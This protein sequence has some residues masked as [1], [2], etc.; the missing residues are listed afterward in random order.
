MNTALRHLQNTVDLISTGCPERHTMRLFQ[1][2]LYSWLL[3]KTVLLLPAATSLWGPHSYIQL[4]DPNSSPLAVPFTLLHRPEVANYFWLFIACQIGCLAAG[5]GGI[6][7]RL[8]ALGIF[9][10]TK[11]LNSR[12]WAT[13]NGGDNLIEILLLFSLFMHPSRHQNSLRGIVANVSSNV[14]FWAA[15]CQLAIVYAVSGLSK[16]QGTL[17]QHGTALYYVL[18]VDEYTHPLGR[19]IA[20]HDWLVTLGSFGTM[21]FMLSFPCLIWFRN[22]RPAL[23]AVGCFLHLQIAILMGLPDFATAMMVGY[24]LFIPDE[25]SQR[26]LDQTPLINSYLTPIKNHP[27]T[28]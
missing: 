28:T 15:Q 10:F 6:C 22:A 7:P 21:A 1:I 18:Q 26:F 4:L 8:T 2:G 12:A 3:A 9:F 13:Q 19:A 25:V 17:W 11:N 5:L 27:A 14:V 16:T 23:I 24:L 20:H